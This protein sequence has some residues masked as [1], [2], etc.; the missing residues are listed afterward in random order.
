[1][2]GEDSV[3]GEE[4]EEALKIVGIS[5]G[6]HAREDLGRGEWGVGSTLPNG[7]GDVEADDGVE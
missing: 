6:E 1:M 4:A 5:G 3:G 2:F 7:V